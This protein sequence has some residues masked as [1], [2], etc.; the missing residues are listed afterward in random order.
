MLPVHRGYR[1][2]T[3]H[4]SHGWGANV[5]EIQSTYE[6]LFNKS[7]KR[8]FRFNENGT[9]IEVQGLSIGEVTLVFH[10][11]CTSEEYQE[12]EQ[13]LHLDNLSLFLDCASRPD[14]GRGFFLYMVL[15]VLD[16]DL[17]LKSSLPGVNKKTRRNWRLFF[18]DDVVSRVRQLRR[19]TRGDPTQTLTRLREDPALFKAHTKISNFLAGNK[20][21][22]FAAKYLREPDRSFIY[23]GS[24]RVQVGD[25][26]VRV[27]GVPQLLILRADIDSPG[28]FR[29][30]SPAMRA[31]LS[32]L[33]H[34]W[35]N[36]A[37][38]VNPEDLVDP[39]RIYRIH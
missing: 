38:V 20:R 12:S 9:S 23:A 24:H 34:S 15:R 33:V 35:A 22:A 2:G 21:V 25:Q 30:I 5:E 11:K 18:R 3:P 6:F 14:F 32:N 31:H 13:G 16:I 37:R 36:S 28:S 29:I 1:T 19:Y 17:N 39:P 27:E 26:I 10:I 8:W 7:T 4:E